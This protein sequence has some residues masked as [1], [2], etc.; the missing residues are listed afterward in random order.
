MGES[1]ESPIKEV[2]FAMLEII[3][4]HSIAIGSLE[5][6]MGCCVDGGESVLNPSH[7]P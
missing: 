2:V 4:A 7:R 6:R 1:E 5:K 3:H